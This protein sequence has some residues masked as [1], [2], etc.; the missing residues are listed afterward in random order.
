MK[1]NT[2]VT[3]LRDRPF[4]ETHELTILFDE[5]TGR[6]QARLSRWVAEGKLIKLRRGKYLL[7]EQQRR[8]EVSDG[9][10]FNYLYGPSYVSLHSALELYGLIPEAVFAIEAVTP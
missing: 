1:Y 2:L 10:L 4:F 5:P 6:V 9:Y 8:K 7:P 3:E